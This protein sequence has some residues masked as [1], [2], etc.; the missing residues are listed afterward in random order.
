MEC[1]GAGV[2][3]HNSKMVLLVHQRASNMWG[4]PKGC[5]E[6]NE[7]DNDCW[8]RELFEETGIRL[9]QHEVKKSFCTLKYNIVEIKLLTDDLPVPSL[10][11][12][13]IADAKWVSFDNVLKYKLN[14]VTSNIFKKHVPKSTFFRKDKNESKQL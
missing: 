4:F 9:V 8:K 5:K 13:E 7:C 11:D 12:N 6:T 1:I 10:K 2:Y 3:L 14:A